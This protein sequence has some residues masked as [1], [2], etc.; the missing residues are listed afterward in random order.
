MSYCDAKVQPVALEASPFLAPFLNTYKQ[1]QTK[2]QCP[3]KL[4]FRRNRQT[5]KP[6]LSLTAPQPLLA[7]PSIAEMF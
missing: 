6:H 3:L 2:P 4:N 5:P 7:V 1:D